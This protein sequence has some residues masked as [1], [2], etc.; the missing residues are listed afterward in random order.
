MEVTEKHGTRS[1]P[2]P[3]HNLGILLN[4]VL[5]NCGPR[6]LTGVGTRVDTCLTFLVWYRWE[7]LHHWGDNPFLGLEKRTGGRGGKPRAGSGV[8]REEGSGI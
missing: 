1:L 6:Q 4:D 5:P 3:Q 8:D 2:K 7:G